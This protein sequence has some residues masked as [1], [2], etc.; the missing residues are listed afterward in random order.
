MGQVVSVG[1]TKVGVLRG[2]Q[3]VLRGP[4]LSAVASVLPSKTPLHFH[5]FVQLLA[6]RPHG[7][8]LSLRGDHF[9]VLVFL[10]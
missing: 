8:L 9:R 6:P 3:W 1:A 4:W 10:W 2:H 5:V 7:P